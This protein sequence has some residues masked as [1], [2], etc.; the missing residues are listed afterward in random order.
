MAN[1]E[2]CKMCGFQESAHILGTIEYEAEGGSADAL[3]GCFVS[4]FP[5]LEECPVL[6]CEGDCEEAIAEADW[7]LM[8]EERRLQQTIFF[9]RRPG[10]LGIDI[11]VLDIGS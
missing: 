10:F 2:R 3:C 5:H 1:G 7:A 4:E 9:V 11:V 6:G 8:V